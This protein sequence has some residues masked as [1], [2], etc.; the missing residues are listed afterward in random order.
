MIAVS[1][2]LLSAVGY[3]LSDFLGGVLSRRGS[4]WPVAV[5]GQ[6]SAA[7]CTGAVALLAG[8][9][10]T[11]AHFAWAA[12]GGAGTAIG[13]GF[14][15]RGLAAGRMGLVAPVSAVG[16]AIVPV[17]VGLGSGERLSWLVGL[18][19]VVA[20]PGIWLVSVGPRPQT[21]RRDGAR[22]LAWRM[23][24]AVPAGLVDGV[25]AG[26]GFGVLF[27]ALGQIPRSAGLL[28][29]ALCQATSVPVLVVVAMALRAAWVP[30][31]RASRLGVLTGP[32]GTVATGAFLLATQHGYLSVAG[33]LASL[34]PAVTVL[35][36]VAILRE[37]IWL[38][39]G[40][41]LALCGVALACI[42]GG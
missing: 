23:P 16:A 9:H 26:L 29:L 41:G 25:A 21:S 15:Y 28:P 31:D 22:R 30:R 4:P 39:Q 37:R 2:A 18:G 24:A 14:L 7:V 20:V 12:L 35:L 33:V 32:L 34:Y 5:A 6:V 1:L 42:A 17:L 8:G 3:G 13:S 27:V 38:R 10:P 11:G 36:A 40:I 19:F